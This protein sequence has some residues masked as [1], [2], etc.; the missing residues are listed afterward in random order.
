MIFSYKI[1]ILLSSDTKG[2]KNGLSFADL[3]K[4]NNFIVQNKYIMKFYLPVFLFG[5]LFL[6]SCGKDDIPVETEEEMEEEMERD[7]CQA[8]TASA[9][10]FEIFNSNL[11]NTFC[12]FLSDTEIGNTVFNKDTFDY[13]A[14]LVLA[15][16]DDSNDTYEWIVDPS[17][18]SAT[19]FFINSTHIVLGDRNESVV[20]YSITL[21]TTKTDSLECS[22]SSLST[23]SATRTIYV[24]NPYTSHLYSEIEGSW[25]GE[26]TA[27]P[28]VPMTVSFT[29]NETIELNFAVEGLVPGALRISATAGARFISISQSFAEDVATCGIGKIDGQG[30][31]IIEYYQHGAGFEEPVKYTF[32]GEKL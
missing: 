12:G 28:G 24:L 8:F 1:V 23:D 25:R 22:G 31:L 16:L 13:P 6:I 5:F 3:L 15:S 10:D 32:K 27:N 19:S 2:L 18:G 21:K 14:T 9:A 26:S 4:F 20:E 17:N 7:S 30:N 11:I 29:P